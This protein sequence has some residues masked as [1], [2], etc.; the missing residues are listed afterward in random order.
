LKYTINC[1]AEFC[2][3]TLEGIYPVHLHPLAVLSIPPSLT[4]TR[5]HSTALLFLLQQSS[6]FHTRENAVFVFLCLTYFT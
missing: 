5:L 1:Q 6:S 4:T 3:R 2:S